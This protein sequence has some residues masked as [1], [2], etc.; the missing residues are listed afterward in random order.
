MKAVVYKRYGPPEV[1]QVGEVAKPVPKDHEILI[2]VRAAEVTKA[3]SEMRS[4]KFAVNWFWL[5]LRLFM[6]IRRPRNPI[7][8]GYF[9]GEVEAVGSA[10]TRFKPGDA[11]FGGT[12]CRNEP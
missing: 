5:P 2:R 8:G 6:G 1:L 3:D 11:L 10:V 7:L 9:S 12:A 4:F